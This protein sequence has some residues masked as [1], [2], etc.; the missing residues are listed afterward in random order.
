MWR[1]VKESLLHICAFWKLNKKLLVGLGF[2]MCWDVFDC[3]GMSYLYNEYI[4]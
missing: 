1:I 2:L 3:V 4:E